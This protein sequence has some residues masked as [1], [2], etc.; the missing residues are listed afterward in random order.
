M[1]H[2]ALNED[3]LPPKLPVVFSNDIH[4]RIESIDWHN[5]NNIEG[6]SQSHDFIDGM[7]MWISNSSIAWDNTNNFQ[8]DSNGTTHIRT[9]GYG[10]AYTIKINEKVNQSY[11]YV[12]RIVFNLEEFCLM[13]R[14]TYGKTT[15]PIQK[16]FTI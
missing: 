13:T 12:F 16:E 7:T 10:V 2:H 11:V 3:K 4:E 1:I 14:I 6:L 15:T 9:H 5:R 8:H